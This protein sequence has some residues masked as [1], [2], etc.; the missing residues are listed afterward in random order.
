MFINMFLWF[1]GWFLQILGVFTYVI[2]HKIQK[3]GWRRRRI[4]TRIFLSALVGII[5]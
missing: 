3:L 5:K 1:R 2:E 4:F